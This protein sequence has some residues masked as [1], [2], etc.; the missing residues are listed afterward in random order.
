MQHRPL[1]QRA[2]ARLV[3][4]FRSPRAWAL[5]LCAILAVP[6]AAHAAASCPDFTVPDSH[7]TPSTSPMASG[8]TIVIDASA[9]DSD[10]FGL[11]G[12]FTQATHGTATVDNSTDTVTYT[13]S[14]SSNTSDHFVFTD[15]QGNKINVTVSI[16]APTSPIVISPDTLPS[17]QFQTPD[18]QTLTATGGT[19]SYTYSVSTGSL[20]AG[21]TL[22]TGG[23]ISGTPTQA[24][25]FAF[26]V[27]VTDSAT[28]VANSKSESYSFTIAAPTI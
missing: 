17:P 23:V 10:G 9:C 7:T 24:G 12:I 8:G 14:G 1:I 5:L 18:S 19:P 28:P 25:T 6:T 21:L 26:S 16:A 3:V 13:N 2:I 22:S 11:G 15:D 27:N 20:P 4:S